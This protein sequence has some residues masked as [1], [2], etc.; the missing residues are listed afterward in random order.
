[1]YD[2]ELPPG[3]APNPPADDT[4]R[5]LAPAAPPPHRRHRAARWL[6]AVALVVLAGGAGGLAV[7]AFRRDVRR[8]V[9]FWRVPASIRT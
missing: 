3:T 1:M 2:D 5:G 7:A 9:A 4:P 8:A 6:G